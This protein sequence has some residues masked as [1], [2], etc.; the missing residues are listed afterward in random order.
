MTIVLVIFVP[1]GMIYLPLL[2]R[3]RRESHACGWKTVISRP[4]T[5]ADQFLTPD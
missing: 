4:L 5:P 3:L 1:Y 2:S